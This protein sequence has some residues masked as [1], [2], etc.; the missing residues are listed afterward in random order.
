MKH[1]TVFI[2]SRKK[3]VSVCSCQLPNGW[4]LFDD[5]QWQTT[6]FIKNKLSYFYF[7]LLFNVFILFLI[8]DKATAWPSLARLLLV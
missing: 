6:D 8:P 1:C 4:P 3:N 2:I 7:S 5:F